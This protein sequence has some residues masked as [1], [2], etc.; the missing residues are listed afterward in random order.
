MTIAGS[1][2]QVRVTD[3]QN[4]QV[5]SNKQVM[6]RWQAGGTQVMSRGQ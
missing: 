6:S 4:E 3:S 2:E 1:D 5:T